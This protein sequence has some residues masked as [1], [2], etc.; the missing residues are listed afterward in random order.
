MRARKVRILAVHSFSTSA[1]GNVSPRNAAAL[2]SARS[3]CACPSLARASVATSPPRADFGKGPLHRSLLIHCPSRLTIASRAP[4]GNPSKMASMRFGVAI[5]RSTMPLAT[6]LHCSHPSS[7]RTRA[8][9]RL[10]LGMRVAAPEVPADTRGPRQM[11]S[12]D[13]RRPANG[14]ASGVLTRCRLDWKGQV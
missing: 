10:P 14:P 6:A 11:A 2:A 13:H 12:P 8:A 5:L 4:G 1:V 9:D 7:M 3:A